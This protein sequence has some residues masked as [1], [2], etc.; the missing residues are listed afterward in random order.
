MAK[1]ATVKATKLSEIAKAGKLRGKVCI[2]D[3]RGVTHEY[4]DEQAA[5]AAWKDNIDSLEHRRGAF[6]VKAAAVEEQPKS[7]RVSR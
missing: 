1:V 7:K 6:F 2:T 5:Y 3:A 4:A